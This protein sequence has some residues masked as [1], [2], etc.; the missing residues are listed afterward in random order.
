MGG[1]ATKRGRYGRSKVI[2]FQVL[3]NGQWVSTRRLCI[4]TG[5]GYYSLGRALPRWIRFDY[6]RRRPC[7]TWRGGDYEYQVTKHGRDWLKIA[8]RDLPSY[9]VFMG[10]LMAWQAELRRGD[11]VEHMLAVPFSEF[12]SDLGESARRVFHRGEE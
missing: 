2:A 3:S 7:T 1:L 12:V 4:L 11:T 10:Q 8:E 5:I 6:V 9:R